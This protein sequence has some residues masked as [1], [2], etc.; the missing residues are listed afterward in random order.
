M[1]SSHAPLYATSGGN[2]S[3]GFAIAIIQPTTMTPYGSPADTTYT[4]TGPTGYSSAIS[5]TVS[6]ACGNS[7][8]GL[9]VNEQFGNGTGQ[10]TVVEDY[11]GANWDV[12]GYPGGDNFGYTAVV[13][14]HLTVGAG[15]YNNE[16]QLYSPTPQDPQNPCSLT[17]PLLH[18]PW[19]FQVG[20]TN[21]TSGLN[22]YSDTQQRYLD[23]RRHQ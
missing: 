17:T 21:P 13:T 14:D 9:D 10:E 3:S 22:I 16:G 8:P 19:Y 18:N 15:E 5:W 2:Q 1:R 20:S 11:S 7:D 4:G 12:T 6:D 23:C